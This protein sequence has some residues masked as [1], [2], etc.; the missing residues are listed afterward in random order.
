MHL[1]DHMF[2]FISKATQALGHSAGHLYVYAYI[3]KYK[4]WQKRKTFIFKNESNCQVGIGISEVLQNV[5]H[6]LKSAL[7][8]RFWHNPNPSKAGLSQMT[9]ELL[10]NVKKRVIIESSPRGSE[11]RRCW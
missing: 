9:D 8:A 1:S 7:V 11:T 6:N 3:H 5:Q 2:I 10:S 4:E